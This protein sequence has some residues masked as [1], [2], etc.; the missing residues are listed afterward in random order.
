MYKKVTD[1][2][3][4]VD[5]EVIEPDDWERGEVDQIIGRMLETSIQMKI[6]EEGLLQT[7]SEVSSALFL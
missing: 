6:E 1:T 5:V 2:T 4:M 3:G 7:V